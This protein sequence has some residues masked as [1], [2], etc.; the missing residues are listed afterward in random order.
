MSAQPVM[1]CCL[2]TSTWRAYDQTPGRPTF[3]CTQA[4]WM[5]AITSCCCS[6]TGRQV[7]WQPQL[8]LCPIIKGSTHGLSCALPS[9]AAVAVFVCLP[10]SAARVS[11]F[12]PLRAVVKEIT[13]VPGRHPVEWQAQL[14]VPLPCLHAGAAEGHMAAC[15]HACLHVAAMSCSPGS[16]PCTLQP[17]QPGLCHLLNCC[18]A[19]S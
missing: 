4:A 13:A 19:H 11:I 15:R 18:T 10:A 12:G 9:K 16:K 5:V 7:C 8:S 3:A 1:L 17:L 6:Q 2:Q 14:G